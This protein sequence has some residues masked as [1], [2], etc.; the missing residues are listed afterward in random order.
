MITIPAVSAAQMAEVD[1][2][3]IEEYGIQLIQMMENAGLRLAEQARRLLGGGTQGRAIVVLCGA[4][5][6]GGGGMAAA[7]HLH[8]W[9]GAVQVVLAGDRAKLKDAPARQWQILQAM[10]VPCMTAVADA[11]PVPDLIVDALIGYGLHGPAG[12]AP[13]GA[14]RWANA[15]AC[16]VLAL[17]V[18]SGLD[19]TSG[20][21]GSPAVRASATLTLALPKTGLL[22]PQAR[23]YVGVLYAADISVPP[24]LWSKIGIDAGLLFA[25]EPIVTV[26]GATGDVRTP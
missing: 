7:R 13:A 19:A 25:R 3:M 16:P 9:G 2:L 22:A 17:D 26:D 23:P 5:N 4:G 15:R 12:G 11:A 8:N 14:I 6:N 24:G 20:D 21:A 10:R 1:R 18:P